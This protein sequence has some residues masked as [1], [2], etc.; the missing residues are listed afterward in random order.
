MKYSKKIIKTAIVI[1]YLLLC[2]MANATP[3]PNVVEISAMQTTL[4]IGEPLVITVTCKFNESQIS[5]KTKKIAESLNIGLLLNVRTDDMTEPK[6]VPL[7]P[8]FSEMIDANGLEYSVQ[9]ALLYDHLADAGM[10]MIRGKHTYYSIEKS[11]E[12]IEQPYGFPVIFNKPGVYFIQAD[13]VYAAVSDELKITVELPTEAEKAA[14]SL[15]ASKENYFFLQIGGRD[16]GKKLSEKI[17]PIQKI[18]DQCGNTFLGK[19]AAARIGVEEYEQTYDKHQRESIDAEIAVARIEMEK[20]G[21]I[22]KKYRPEFDFRSKYRKGQLKEPAFEH[23]YTHLKK[24]LELPDD[25]PIRERVLKNLMDV[26]LLKGNDAAALTY[27]DEVRRKYP[28]SRLAKKV[29]IE[30][31]EARIAKAEEKFKEFEL[32]EQKKIEDMVDFLEQL[33]IEDESIKENIDPNQ[34]LEFIEAVK[35]AK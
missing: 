23:A 18:V 15:L 29:S 24:A 3:E 8:E 26:E 7:P 30:A 9:F 19:W 34:W 27:A 33:W 22:Q 32:A 20:Y 12:V 13:A 1:S 21:Q 28:N 16:P 31:M 10:K 2:S 4:K 25:F 11:E 14:L 35:K 6:M 5:H 17:T